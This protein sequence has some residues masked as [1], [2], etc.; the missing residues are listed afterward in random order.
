MPTVV[1]TH[2]APSHE[3]GFRKRTIT[4]GDKSACICKK[5]MILTW[6]NCSVAKYSGA[7]KYLCFD[8]NQR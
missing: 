8:L 4:K 2:L 5:Q 7:S 3:K 6:K 1:R